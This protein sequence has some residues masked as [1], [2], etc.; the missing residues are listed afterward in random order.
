[1]ESKK[2]N[3]TQ[4]VSSNRIERNSQRNSQKLAE[5]KLAVARGAREVSEIN[6]GDSE[7]SS[8]NKSGECKV[9]PREYSPRIEISLYGDGY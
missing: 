6:E 9:Q 8:D 2:I 5:N 1:M 3:D 7:Q 4:Q